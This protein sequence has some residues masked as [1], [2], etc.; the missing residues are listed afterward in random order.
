[1]SRRATILYEDSLGRTSRK[2]YGPHELVAAL[3]ADA[4][5]LDRLDILG[6]LRPHPTNGNRK[7]RTKCRKGVG[8]RIAPDCR[9]V[10]AVYDADKVAGLDPAFSGLRP[11]QI[12]DR[13]QQDC[14]TPGKLRV[15][16]LERNVETII[17]TLARIEPDA[18]PGGR[19][20]GQYQQALRKEVA[21]RDAILCRV[22]WGG[23][24]MRT[25][26]E[27]LLAE[28]PSLAR[29]LDVVREV[30]DSSESCRTA[31]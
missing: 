28:V 10:V 1:M 22:A 5:G 18:K 2:Q 23:E 26:R 31:P 21:A 27:N 6:Q 9:P 25:V 19:L 3:L 11:E 17:E 4:T 8:V 14:S 20:F 13:L 16:L 24:P 7:L 15:V 29:I 12:V 30:W